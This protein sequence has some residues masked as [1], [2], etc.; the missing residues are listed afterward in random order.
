[1]NSDVWVTHFVETDN[2]LVHFVPQDDLE[3]DA[4]HEACGKLRFPLFI[5]NAQDIHSVPALMVALAEAMKFPDGP[6]S[7]PWWLRSDVSYD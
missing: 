4:M 6:D 1:M 3:V 5:V 2:A 7:G